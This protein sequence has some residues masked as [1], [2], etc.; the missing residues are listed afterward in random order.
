MLGR[1]ITFNKK[2]LNLRWVVG[3]VIYRISGKE[4]RTLSHSLLQAR[5]DLE[6]RAI[7]LQSQQD[8]LDY[9][10]NSRST[11]IHAYVAEALSLAAALAEPKT[12]TKK[13]FSTGVLNGKFTKHGSDK[14]TRHNYAETYS[15]IL[16]GIDSPHILEIGLGSLNGF[17]YGGLAPG[18]SIKAWREAYPEAVIVGADIDPDAVASISEI[19]FVLDQTSDQSLDD[20]IIMV[21][22]FAPFDLIVD[23][24]FHDPHANFRTLLKIFPLTAAKGSYVIEDVHN[25]LINFWKVIAKT[26]DAHLEV[27][28]LSTD[29]PDTDDNFLL[30]FTKREGRI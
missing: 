3:K 15:E 17:P 28:D 18:G 8:E 14:E 25:S 20:F 2:F 26:I 24:G 7:E 19:G 27:R 11:R 5:I 16:D 12:V 1:N 21:S 30:I 29:R 6:Q 23:D 9:L 10:R 13:R 22:K 4:A